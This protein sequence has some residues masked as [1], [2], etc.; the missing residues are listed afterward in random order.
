MENTMTMS[1]SYEQKMRERRRELFEQAPGEED[2]V[3]KR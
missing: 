1:K 2:A 3:E